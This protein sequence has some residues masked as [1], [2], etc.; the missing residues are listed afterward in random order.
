[1]D[2]W[3]AVGEGAAI[4][5]R[6]LCVAPVSISRWALIAA[7]PVVTREVP[8]FTLIVGVPARRAVW[9]G[10]AGEPIQAKDDGRW[11]CPRTG[12]EYRECEGRLT[13]LPSA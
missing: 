5:T 13:E 12:A 9:V 1:M 8:D 7:G 11:I 6:P 2:D 3:T 4:G 10:R